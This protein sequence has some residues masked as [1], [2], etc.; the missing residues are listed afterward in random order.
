LESV[1][2]AQRDE[3]DPVSKD[4]LIQIA[5]LDDYQD[6]ALSMADWSPLLNRA[7]ITV[8][9]DHVEDREALVDRLQPFDVL[10]VMRERTPLP[11][12]LLQRLV[13]LK[14]IVSTGR[15]NASI[16]ATAA[17]ELGITV[18]NTGYSAEPTIE[19]T[20]ALILATARHL[21]DEAQSVRAGLWQRFLGVGLAGKT[22]GVVGLGNIG[23]EVARIGAAFGMDVVAWSEN[24]T[25]ARAQA[26]GA[27]YVSKEELFRTADI[28][29]IH[30][31]LSSRTRGLIGRSELFA[32][33]PSALLVNTSR[34]PIVDEAALIEALQAN[35]IQGAA[36]DVFDREPLPPEHPFRT[37]PSVLPTPHIGYVTDDL[38]RVFYQDTVANITS[39]LD[40]QR[41]GD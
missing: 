21:V 5:V 24:L 4:A 6:V 2:F 1:G 22:L 36:I 28:V 3:H 14:L 37:L 41:P 12:E 9:H 18:A 11:R 8:F 34:G 32:M 13:R 23:T 33:K 40:S 30:L 26:G 10:C 38:Y 7:E 31:V 29:T 35:A 20:W 25:P 15:R 27:R 16:D 39:W 19:F 17:N